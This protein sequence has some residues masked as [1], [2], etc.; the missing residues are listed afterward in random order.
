MATKVCT[1]IP[2]RILVYAYIVY[3]LPNFGGQE[4][5]KTMCGFRIGGLPKR[6]HLLDSSYPKP[7]AKETYK[8]C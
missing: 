3:G 4:N 8:P 7:I 5:S 6:G 1:Y 2:I